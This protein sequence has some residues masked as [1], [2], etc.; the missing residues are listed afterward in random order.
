MKVKVIVLP[1]FSRF[2]MFCALLD[3]DIRGVF[4]GPLVL[5][6]LINCHDTSTL[7]YQSIY[8][9]TLNRLINNLTLSNSM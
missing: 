2:C 6:L 4:T 7:E 1:L 5:W 9:D 8:S 3:Q